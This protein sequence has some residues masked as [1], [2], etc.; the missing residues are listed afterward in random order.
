MRPKP[1][2]L[3]SFAQD[4]DALTDHLKRNWDGLNDVKPKGWSDL[5]ENYSDFDG[6]DE[7]KERFQA[8][9]EDKFDGFNNETASSF[10]FVAQTAL[11]NVMYDDQCQGREPIRILVSAAM[12]YGQYRGAIIQR[13]DDSKSM[14]WKI[15]YIKH[16]IGLVGLAGRNP[17]EITELLA[18]I[19]QKIRDIE[20]AMKSEVYL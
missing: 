17:S 9:Q 3:I 12:A 4:A 11:P 15:D 7:W 6:Y 13:A 1:K 2:K 19:K 14:G 16:L 20:D 5:E 10:N 8:D 18:D